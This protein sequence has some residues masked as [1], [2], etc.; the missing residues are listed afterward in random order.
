MLL[1]LCAATGFKIVIGCD[2]RMT[3][4]GRGMLRSE[5]SN[6]SNMAEI[7]RA[8]SEPKESLSIPR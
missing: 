1:R 6:H 3:G 4:E 7:L 8:S 2:V 5:Q